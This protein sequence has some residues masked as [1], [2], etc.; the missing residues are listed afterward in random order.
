[1]RTSGRRFLAVLGSSLLLAC[2]P[3]KQDGRFVPSE[4]VD[5]G[6][7]VTPD[8]PQRL[9]G[10]RFLTQM[11]FTRPNSFEVITWKFPVDQGIIEGSNAYYT[12]FNH[13]GPHVDAPKHMSW[14]GGIDSYPIDAFSGPLRVFDV[15]SYPLGRSVPVQVFQ[16][17][18]RPGDVVLIFTAY[19]PPQSDTAMPQ[20]R[21]LT[22]EAAEYLA[23]LPVRA[24]GTDAFSVE[25]LDD[26]KVPWIHRS[27]LARGIPVYEHL[28][29]VAKLLDRE[30]AFF[31][32]V[33]L[34]VKEGDGM[35][36]RPVAFLY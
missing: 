10:K 15:T 27:F 3:S 4:V 23:G 20:V 21:T 36:V 25:S 30:R 13:G 33:P 6:T 8:L 2:S 32:G 26:T 22:S 5:L 24:Y 11:G 7:L 35:M 1:M 18:V 16:D 31:V 29:N 9:W 28:F 14:G 19:T 34:N 17:K 12:L